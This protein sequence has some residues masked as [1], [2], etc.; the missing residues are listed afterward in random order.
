VATVSGYDLSTYAGR[1]QARD[2]NP[3]SI[4]DASSIYNPGTGQQTGG[5]SSSSNNN[6]SS[7][8][9]LGAL[10]GAFN[11]AGTLQQKSLDEQKRE[12]DANLQFQKDQ[13]EKMGIPQVVINQR[14]AQLQQDEFV[15]QSQMAQQDQALQ[16]AQI[17][18]YYQPPNITNPLDPS[19]S[20][21]NMSQA[22]GAAGASPTLTSNAAGA[23]ANGLPAGAIPTLAAQ[24]QWAQLFGQNGAPSAGQQTLAALQQ[25]AEMTGMFNGQQ[26]QAAQ[27]QAFN[28]AMQQQGMGLQALQMASQLQGP[29]NWV[30]AANFARGVSN[31][32]IPVFLQ[33]MLSGTTSPAAVGG[34]GLSNP[35]TLGSLAGSLGAGKIS[36]LPGSNSNPNLMQFHDTHREADASVSRWRG[37]CRYAHV[38]AA[39]RKQPNRPGSGSSSVTD[40]RVEA[41]PNS[42][43]GTAKNQSCTV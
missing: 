34:S 35:L 4:V 16:Q 42:P 37:W 7:S 14:L 30:Q 6:N 24:A 32:N 5:T 27:L 23:T 12:F 36:G 17:L 26:T 25:A 31:S 8:P 22:L 41:W 40:N 43:F 29:Q 38:P 28:E 13:M 19:L 3:G 11:V 9:N 18:G 20:G 21:T 2:E 33:N 15:F 1:Q 39:V 10:A